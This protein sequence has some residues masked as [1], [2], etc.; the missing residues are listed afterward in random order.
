[1]QKRKRI[2]RIL[3]LVILLGAGFHLSGIESAF[4]DD[5]ALMKSDSHG[6]QVCHPGGHAVANLERAASIPVTEPVRFSVISE[7]FFHPQ[8]PAFLFFHPPIAR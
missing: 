6:C 5:T 1:M 4:C 7:T 8:E 2:L 3:A